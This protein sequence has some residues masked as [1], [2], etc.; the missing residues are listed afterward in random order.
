MKKKIFKRSHPKKKEVQVR[1]LTWFIVP[2]FLGF[3]CWRF[4][5]NG[6]RD[7]N[8]LRFITVMVFPT[9]RKSKFCN[10]RIWVKTMS[11]FLVFEPTA[12]LGPFNLTVPNKFLSFLQKRDFLEILGNAYFQG[13]TV[14]FR[15][16]TL[17]YIIPNHFHH[18]FFKMEAT[19][20]SRRWNRRRWK[21]VSQMVVV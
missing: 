15:E 5:L 6:E 7:A 13:R 8:K 14:R 17:Q 9:S 1:W 11:F 19:A 10:L 21:G 4:F 18:H 20:F 16:G 12:M 3:V 2:S